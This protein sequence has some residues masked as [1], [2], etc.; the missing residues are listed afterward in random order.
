LT[1]DVVQKGSAPQCTIL[2]QTDKTPIGPVWQWET[3]AVVHNLFRKAVDWNRRGKQVVDWSQ[4]WR[5]I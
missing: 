2:K 3:R 4:R 1:Q 5:S